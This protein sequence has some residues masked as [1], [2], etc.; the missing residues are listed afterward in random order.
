MVLNVRLSIEGTMDIFPEQ[1]VDWFDYTKTQQSA[2]HLNNDT[3]FLV[4]FRSERSTLRSEPISDNW[5]SFK[6]DKNAK[7]SC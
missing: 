4:A 2:I 1:Q 3:C 7:I 6:S 5:T